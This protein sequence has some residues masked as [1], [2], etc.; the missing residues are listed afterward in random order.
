MAPFITQQELQ[1]EDKE[2]WSLERKINIRDG[3]YPKR[4]KW[5]LPLL[6]LKFTG[7]Q[8][9][10][11]HAER[12]RWRYR[13]LSFNPRSSVSFKHLIPG[14]SCPLSVGNIGRGVMKATAVLASFQLHTTLMTPHC[15][16]T[17]RYFILDRHRR[18]PAQHF[19]F[20]GVLTSRK[21]ANPESNM[22]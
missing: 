3:V 19:Q 18:T 8:Q 7:S 11:E 10:H 9:L 16:S 20:L 17:R 6:P 15:F 4:G 22:S 12:S 14:T 1:E 13:I 2:S 21:R 5:G